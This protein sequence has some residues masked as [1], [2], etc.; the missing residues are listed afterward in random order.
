MIDNLPSL[1]HLLRHLQ[2][3]PYFASRHVYRIA[4]H[5]LEMDS[6][7]LQQF[8]NVLL[9]AKENLI[10]CP[11]C[12]V[13]KE[14]SGKCL[15]CD[16]EKRDKKIICVVESWYDL[17]AIERTNSYNGV[18]HVLGG[19]ICPLE[20]IGPEDLTI[21]FLIA[22]I[23]NQSNIENIEKT[24]TFN[25]NIESNKKTESL[26]LELKNISKNFSH[27]I[28]LALNQT[29]EGEATS[30]YIAKKLSPFNI[31]ITCLARG[32]PV[33]SALENL[34]KLTVH[35]ALNERRPF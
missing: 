20:G 19:S 5:F 22:R 31:K 21:E 25:S 3:I 18:Y 34:D 6:Q 23:K 33:G 35:K 11:Q 26:E 32:M 7:N 14:K 15:F 8:C 24:K 4:Q 2:Q 1:K 13:W 30:A 10:K 28:I 16:N 12:C 9:H 27:E 17:W 29:P